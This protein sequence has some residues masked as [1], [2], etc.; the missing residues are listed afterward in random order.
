MVPPHHQTPPQQTLFYYVHIEMVMSAH[1]HFEVDRRI[2]LL[3][4]MQATSCTRRDGHVC[5]HLCSA[6]RGIGR[7]GWL[8]HAGFPEGIVPC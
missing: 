2:R 8:M 5:A 6:R 4:C 3:R 7:W 1:V